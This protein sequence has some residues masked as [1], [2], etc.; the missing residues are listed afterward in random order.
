MEVTDREGRKDIQVVHVTLDPRSIP[1]LGDAPGT[2]FPS[3][4]A[5]R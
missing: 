1:V 3:I 4:G 5:G 2:V